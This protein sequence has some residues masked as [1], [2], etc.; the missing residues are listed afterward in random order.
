[1]KKVIAGLASVAVALSGFAVQVG[2]QEKDEAKQNKKERIVIRT[3]KAGGKWIGV[4]CTPLSPALQAQ[5][6]LKDGV[7]VE[8]VAD[9]SPAKKAGLKP[10][11]I[12]LEVNGKRVE[13]VEMLTKA[14][15]GKKSLAMTVMSGGKKRNV[16]LTPADRPKVD[17]SIAGAK[18]LSI[19]EREL[20]SGELDKIR[21]LLKDRTDFRVIRPGIRLNGP[22]GV[23]GG[24]SISINKTNDGP[25]KITVKKGDKTWEVTED[26]LDKLPKDIRKH[27]EGM[28]KGKNGA[29]D[30]RFNVSP[31]IRLNPDKIRQGAK[32]GELEKQL[33]ERFKEL[34][35]RIE[36][37]HK[38]LES[39][40]K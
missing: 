28:V 37:L 10:Y 29:S 15:D 11:D 38:E 2:A 14:V 25:A 35:K 13:G 4:A 22:L 5:L 34:Q 33:E 16:E 18:D 17:S 6:G 31:R 21:E 26:S 7:M 1:M 40:R 3:A 19:I 36:E 39:I 24:L 23:E 32:G 12:I 30:F 8:R 20:S 9:D 27:V